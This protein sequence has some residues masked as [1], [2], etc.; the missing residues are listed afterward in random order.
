MG[1]Q[2]LDAIP[3]LNCGIAFHNVAVTVGTLYRTTEFE[4]SEKLLEYAYIVVPLVK[5]SDSRQKKKKIQYVAWGQGCVSMVECL[6][7]LRKTPVFIPSHSKKNTVK[8]LCLYQACLHC[9]FLTV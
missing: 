5:E 4:K 8:N 1:S 6:S 9:L 3:M 2:M 7:S